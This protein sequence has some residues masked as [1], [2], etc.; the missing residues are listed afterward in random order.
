MSKYCKS[1]ILVNDAHFSPVNQ[2]KI[3][4]KFSVFSSFHFTIH[5]TWY[6]YLAAFYISPNIDWLFSFI[7]KGGIRIQFFLDKLMKI[8]GKQLNDGFEQ[9]QWGL[10]DCAALLQKMGEEIAEKGEMGVWHLWKLTVIGKR[11]KMEGSSNSISISSRSNDDSF[12][13][14]FMMWCMFSRSRKKDVKEAAAGQKTGNQQQKRVANAASVG[15]INNRSDFFLRFLFIFTNFSRSFSLEN[16]NQ[17]N[18]FLVE[19]FDKWEG[20]F[21]KSRKI[22]AF[23]GENKLILKIIFRQGP[24]KSTSSELCVCDS[25]DDQVEVKQIF[26]GKNEPFLTSIL[27]CHIFHKINSFSF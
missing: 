12:H 24:A 20:N 10:R 6:I 26:E 21:W 2:W 1:K 8:I 16:F 18:I 11:Q 23:W 27:L 7:K 14:G 15:G 9:L 19:S 17:K 4:F 25:I 22:V 5:E 13:S 3:F